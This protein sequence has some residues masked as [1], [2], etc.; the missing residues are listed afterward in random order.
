MGTDFLTFLTSKYRVKH[1]H[2]FSNGM[3]CF[4][5]LKIRDN[6]EGPNLKTTF[7]LRT[8]DKDIYNFPLN[9]AYFIFTPRSRLYSIVE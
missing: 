2:T 6:V 3:F 4:P 1:T 8:T 5:M 7:V 9:I